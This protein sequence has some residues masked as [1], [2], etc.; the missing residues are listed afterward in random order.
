[1]HAK[2]YR[3]AYN[4]SPT[5]IHGD[6]E[7]RFVNADIGY[8]VF[9]TR[10]IPKGTITWVRDRLDQAFTP[11]DIE[12][13][14]P[15][16]HDLV[17]KYSFID[18]RGKFVLCWDHARFMNHSCEATC[19]SAGYD[20]ELAVRD[21]VPGE[22][23]TDD[24]GTLNLEYAFECCCRSSRCRGRIHPRDLLTYAPEWDRAVAEPFALIPSVPQPLWPFLEERDAV[25]A[26][27]AGRTPVASVSRNFVDVTSLLGGSPALAQRTAAP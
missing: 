9:A 6:T 20:F 5:V 1:M 13:M 22:E 17:H 14:P 3:R 12:R 11:A 7:L 15:A 26:A 23:L 8:G 25:E 24:Y 10:L 4:L 21:I 19:L 2:P 18:A 16:Y 27:L